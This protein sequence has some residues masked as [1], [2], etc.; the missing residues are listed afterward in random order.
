MN[1]K[2]QS[3]AKLG[4]VGEETTLEP[5]RILNAAGVDVTPRALFNPLKYMSTALV[6]IGASSTAPSRPG[7]GFTTDSSPSSLTQSVIRQDVVV[8]YLM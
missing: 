7:P 5:V 2:R 8:V 3:I 4:A 6:G 1:A